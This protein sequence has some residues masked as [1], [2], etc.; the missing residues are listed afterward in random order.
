V[1]VTAPPPVLV[2]VAPFAVVASRK[3]I[4]PVPSH[5]RRQCSSPVRRS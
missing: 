1:T 2:I 4:D 3:L 5:S